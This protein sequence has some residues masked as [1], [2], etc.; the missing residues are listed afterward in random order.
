MKN[1]PI[2]L[3]LFFQLVI[4]YSI[5]QNAA[6]NCICVDNQGIQSSLIFQNSG[7]SLF[8]NPDKSAI[9]PDENAVLYPSL[10]VAG[11]FDGDGIDETALFYDYTY[12]PNDRPKAIGSKVLIFKNIG[13][14]MI[15]V[16]TWFTTLKTDIDF[17]KATFAVSGD[18]NKDENTD[19]ALIYNPRDADSQSV[20]VLESTG[21]EFSVAKEYFKV[22]RSD[23]NFSKL[24]SVVS[25]DFNND[26]TT[27]LCGFYSY[28]DKGVNS[29]QKLF[30]FESTGSAFSYPEPYYSTT[31]AT[32]DMSTFSFTVSGDFNGDGLVDILCVKNDV[33]TDIQSLLVLENTGTK[34]FV[35][36]DYL[37]PIRSDINFSSI[38]KAV[39]GRFDND[40]K[41]DIALLYDNTELSTQDILVFESTGNSFS[42]YKK[43]FSLNNSSFSFNNIVSVVS[44]SFIKESRISPTVWL[45]NKKG[46]VTFG[47]DDGYLKAIQNGGGFLAKKKL[48]GTFYII[49]DVASND[50]PDYANWDTIKYYNRF[51]HEF[52]SHTAN[53]KAVGRYT[54]ADSLL[55]LNQLLAK[56]KHDLDSILQQNTVSMSYPFGSF[57]YQSISQVSKHFLNVRSSQSGYNL[58]TPF[59]FFV[60]KSKFISSSTTPSV[61]DSWFGTAENYGYHLSLMYHNIL[62][63]P[64]DKEDPDNEY[65]YSLNDF[66]QNV[67]D[68]IKHDLWIDTQ[69]AIYK[70]TMERNKI[71]LTQYTEFSDTVLVQVNDGLDDTIYN[72]EVTFK[73]ELPNLWNVD[74]VTITN[75]AKIS[76]SPVFSANS[77]RYC[78][79]NA[80]PDNS[81]IKLS[82]P[83]FTTS[84]KIPMDENSY[85]LKCYKNRQK[86]EA[87][88]SIK[89]NVAQGMGVLIYNILG[90][91]VY[92][93]YN[94]NSNE[95]IINES[96]IGNGNLI[97][98]LVNKDR[99]VLC[100]SKVAL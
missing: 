92:S 39:S 3:F 55:L 89:G 85:A 14:T 54:G 91:K 50:E 20:L 76:K 30:V 84:T 96:L 56:S 74:S 78:Y 88:I 100:T 32:L 35:Q 17:S 41:S 97:C 42:A 31:R 6:L 82:K 29:L 49:T 23:F 43:Y 70:Y 22:D 63:E 26:G 79:V 93:N 90:M 12:Y 68:A 2:K 77:K 15:P 33:S 87:T 8:L 94:I 21:S 51:G 57:S 34:S 81:I 18:F 86:K 95:L 1:L 64:F 9:Q 75:A 67:N 59:D 37:A 11:D 60:L 5:G 4:V 48:K 69:S 46:A 45:N 40:N 52:C 61:I 19:I 72:Q 80:L 16:G 99:Q 73:I 24:K 36:K 58:Q 83:G 25:G 44:G 65:F 27:D 98:F 28:N 10:T 38:K 66:K 71:N 53:H 7:G 47:F 13:G 62:S